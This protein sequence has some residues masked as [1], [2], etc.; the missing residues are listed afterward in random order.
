MDLSMDDAPS[1]AV[2]AAPAASFEWLNGG[3]SEPLKPNFDWSGSAPAA[4]EPAFDSTLVAEAAGLVGEAKVAEYERLVAIATK[5]IGEG[6][7]LAKAAKKCRKAIAL[8]PEQSA[9]HSAL[10]AALEATGDCLLAARSYLTAMHKAERAT[11]ADPRLWADA[12]ARAYAMLVR[13]PEEPRPAWW[14]DEELLKLSEKAVLLLPED[15]RAVK[16][17]ADVLSGLQSA[18]PD[19]TEPRGPQ[20]LREAA[21][22]FQKVATLLQSADAKR[23]M[24]KAGVACRARAD[25]MERQLETQVG[26]SH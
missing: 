25:D 20:S 3:T 26:N 17:R 2:P 18:L 12:A 24:I 10:G 15:M 4:D 9:A 14:H 11:D 23:S 6:N 22:C 16:W 1:S 5:M 13:C 8:F 21:V 19:D 7:T